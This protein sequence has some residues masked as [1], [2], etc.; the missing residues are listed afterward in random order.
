MQISMCTLYTKLKQ[1]NS[2]ADDCNNSMESDT[3]QQQPTQ[4]THIANEIERELEDDVMC[5][6]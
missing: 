1:V 2:I 6:G 4:S 3:E 5:R